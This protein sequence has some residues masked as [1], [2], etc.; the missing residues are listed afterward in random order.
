MSVCNVSFIR[1]IVSQKDIYARGMLKT[2]ASI[3]HFCTITWCFQVER[4]R[5]ALITHTFRQL[6]NHYNRRTNNSSTPLAAH[7]VKVIFKDEPGE[8]SGVARSFYTAVANVSF[9]RIVRYFEQITVHTRE[10]LKTTD[11]VISNSWHFHIL[12]LFILLCL[13]RF[14]K[15]SSYMFL[16]TLR[17][18]CQKK[19]CHRL[20][21]C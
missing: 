18:C 20:R 17:R 15:K 8:G 21:G 4:E 5:S 10:Q 7:R 1:T 14:F 16:F 12:F 6:N 13:Y 9:C 19:N 11:N 2:C 3:L